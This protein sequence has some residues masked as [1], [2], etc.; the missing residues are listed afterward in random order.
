[1]KNKKH[2]KRIIFIAGG[3]L[4]ILIFFL[5]LASNTILIRSDFSG[6]KYVYEGENVIDIL[7]DGPF[8]YGMIASY[9]EEN[10]VLDSKGNVTEKIKIYTIEAGFS[11][12]QKMNMKLH[13]E[14]S[15]EIIYT[16]ILKFADKDVKII[17]GKVAE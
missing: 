5:L 11:L 14:T 8:L 2:K 1:M 12:H 16:Y 13:I 17:N 10:L 3:I 15:D 7:V 6:V 4:G 9:P